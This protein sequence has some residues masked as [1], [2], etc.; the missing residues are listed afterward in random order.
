[1]CLCVIS[2]WD[3]SLTV[4][5]IRPISLHG[6]KTIDWFDI[7]FCKFNRQHMPGTLSMSSYCLALS[8]I[9]DG[10]TSSSYDGDVIVNPLS[11]SIIIACY[12]YYH[13][14]YFFVSQLLFLWFCTCVIFFF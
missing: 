13:C 6:K 9:S 1:M 5:Q 2:Y 3:F 11:I 7:Y 14:C 10:V 12:Y 4:Y 8:Q